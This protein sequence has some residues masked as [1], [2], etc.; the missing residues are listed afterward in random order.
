[1]KTAI[2]TIFWGQDLGPQAKM[3]KPGVITCERRG[4]WAAGM[5]RH[6]PED[7]RLRETRHLPDCLIELQTT[8]QSLVA[9]ELTPANVERVL[10]FVVEVERRFPLARVIVVAERGMESHEWLLREAG[11]MHFTTSP[12]EPET[13]AR[14][15]VRHAA[16]TPLPRTTLMK[17]IWDLLPWAEAAVK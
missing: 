1:M 11:A 14:L 10:A 16:Q 13:L 6:L 4:L 3:S 17:Q 8:P 2:R 15:A 5:R 9:V 7:I 12:R